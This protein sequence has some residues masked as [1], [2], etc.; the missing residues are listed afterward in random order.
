MYCFHKNR[1]YLAFVR[2]SAVVLSDKKQVRMFLCFHVSFT[3]ASEDQWLIYLDR[4]L[5]SNVFY[6]CFLYIS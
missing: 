1:Q 6:L 2:S 4:L 5:G 3:F